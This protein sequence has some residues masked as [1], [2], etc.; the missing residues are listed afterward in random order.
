MIV[1][2]FGGTSI[3]NAEALKRV[4]DIVK[5]GIE[6]GGN[7]FV[8]VSAMGKATRRLAHLGEAACA[9]GMKKAKKLF[10]DLKKEHFSVLEEGCANKKTASAAKRALS[11]EFSNLRKFI[12]RLG[13][14]KRLT[15]RGNDYIVSFGERISSIIVHAALRASGINAKTV[16]A[17]EF[18]ITDNDYTRAKPLMGQVYKKLARE[19]KP[20]FKNHTVLLTQGFIAKSAGGIHTTIGREGSDCT[21]AIV[22]AGL[23]A[24]RV[25]I[26]TDVNGVMTCDPKITGRAATIRRISYGDMATLACLGAKV[27]H[28]DTIAPAQNKKIP[29]YV[30]NSYDKKNKGTVIHDFKKNKNKINDLIAITSKVSGAGSAVYIIGRNI[31]YSGRFRKIIDAAIQETGAKIK[32]ISKSTITL[33]VKADKAEEL[34]RCLHDRLIK[35]RVGG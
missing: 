2:K 13:L 30:L 20:Y 28:P 11:A 34:M 25:E 7:I 31:S 16:S 9:A 6:R 22:G 14:S 5:C 29:V 33:T 1:M 3:Q 35:K 18:M 27:L 26:W 10:D 24:K 19:V 32:N 4:I 12:K 8:V 21:A 15:P 17:Y 23:G